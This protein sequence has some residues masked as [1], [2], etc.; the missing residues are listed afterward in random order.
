MLGYSAFLQCS[1]S[2]CISFCAQILSSFALCLAWDRARI[3]S[4]FLEL[5]SHRL[6]FCEIVLD[7]FTCF[8][9]DFACFLFSVAWKITFGICS[10]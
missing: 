10:F 4:Q 8:G 7:L 3:L 1:A 5:L 6:K 9:G 2:L